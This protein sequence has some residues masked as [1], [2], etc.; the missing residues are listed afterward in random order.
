MATP[1]TLPL[2]LQAHKDEKE[3]KGLVK[4]WEAARARCDS[5]EGESAAGSATEEEKLQSDGSGGGRAK[6]MGSKSEHV[7][8]TKKSGTRRP[9][10][11]KTE[12]GLKGQKKKLNAEK[13]AG[14]KE[15]TFSS[16]AVEGR[17]A[18]SDL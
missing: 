17:C 8:A 5:L 6:P 7:G 16:M 9:A 11:G 1:S 12:D 14:T 4:L 3:K 13:D 10:K 2:F 15:G 18:R